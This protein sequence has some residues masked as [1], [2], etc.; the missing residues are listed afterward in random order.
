MVDG[1]S[2]GVPSGI[3]EESGDP[4][5]MGCMFRKRHKLHEMRVLHS[6]VFPA[7]V[8]MPGS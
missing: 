3:A 6:P 4:F 5:L 7:L 8:I 2:G 1:G